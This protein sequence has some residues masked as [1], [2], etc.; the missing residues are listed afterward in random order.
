L[1]ERIAK[2]K[3][4]DADMLVRHVQK[5]TYKVGG[6]LPSV[7][8]EDESRL[9]VPSEYLS[10]MSKVLKKGDNLSTGSNND[11]SKGASLIDIIQDEKKDLSNRDSI[12]SSNSSYEDSVD[13]FIKKVRI[14][15]NAA[16]NG[17]ID[18][19]DRI[20]ESKASGIWLNGLKAKRLADLSSSS[21]S[22]SNDGVSDEASVGSNK[23]VEE[24]AEGG[25]DLMIS[26][27]SNR[28]ILLPPPVDGYEKKIEE[29]MKQEQELAPVSPQLIQSSNA[30]VDMTAVEMLATHRGYMLKSI[31]NT[32]N[33]NKQKVI[34]EL[35]RNNFLN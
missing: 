18:L 16:K 11:A 21:E 8:Q 12:K 35:L 27:P 30:L 5:M 9:L 6:I 23:D 26:S 15:E 31:E 10:T 19:P 34:V 22:T 2:K 25:A 14:L 17:D 7:T 24:N 20:S 4:S 13:S 32:E 1:Q 3:R 28:N 29:L 33:S